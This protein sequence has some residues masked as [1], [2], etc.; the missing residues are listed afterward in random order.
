[1]VL[2]VVH[3]KDQNVGENGN[4]V[5]FVQSNYMQMNTQCHMFQRC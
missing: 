4:Y 2:I 5:V 1:M 3:I